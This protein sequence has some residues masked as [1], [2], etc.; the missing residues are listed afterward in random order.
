VLY[1]FPDVFGVQADI[2]V[3][4]PGSSRGLTLN[5]FP[6]SLYHSRSSLWNM[7]YL[8]FARLPKIDVRDAVGVPWL[9]HHFLMAMSGRERASITKV[10][11]GNVIIHNKKAITSI[12]QEYTGKYPGPRRYVLGLKNDGELH[13]NK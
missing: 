3:F 5:S 11:S 13:L 9:Q 4:R 12:F 2:A 7:H 10:A 1:S 8:N 6:V